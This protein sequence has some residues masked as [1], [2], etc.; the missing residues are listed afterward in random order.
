MKRRPDAQI[1]KKKRE[2]RNGRVNVGT[3]LIK[4]PQTGRAISTGIKADRNSFLCSAVFFARTHCPICA[5]NHEWFSREAWV[6]EP[7]VDR[8]ELAAI[9]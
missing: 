5:T 8:G 6:H 9:S 7:N 4:C 2:E 3:V 1:R